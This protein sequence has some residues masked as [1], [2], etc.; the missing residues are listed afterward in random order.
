[1]LT[2]TS[3]RISISSWPLHLFIVDDGGAH[4]IDERTP[5]AVYSWVAFV[6]RRKNICY[7]RRVGSTVPCAPHR[8]PYWLRER[9]SFIRPP[10]PRSLTLTIQKTDKERSIAAITSVQAI[11]FAKFAEWSSEINGPWDTPPALSLIVLHSFPSISHGPYQ[12]WMAREAK[13]S[14]V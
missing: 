12:Y 11:K 6:D 14:R 9:V 1:M 13:M 10:I 5:L 3:C 7:W 8:P 2:I 4:C